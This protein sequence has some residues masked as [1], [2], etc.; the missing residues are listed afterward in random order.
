MLVGKKSGDPLVGRLA[1]AFLT[2]GVVV[3]ASDAVLDHPLTNARPALISPPSAVSMS[4]PVCG[5]SAISDG[6]RWKPSFLARSMTRR[7]TRYQVV[8]RPEVGAKEE[9]VFMPQD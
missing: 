9:G 5:R 4:P 8:M 7:G 2:L 1:L 6:Q 3:H